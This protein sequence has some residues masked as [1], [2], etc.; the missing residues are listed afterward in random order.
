MEFSSTLL[1]GEPPFCNKFFVHSVRSVHF[2][3]H[4]EGECAVENHK[5][6]LSYLTG[7]LGQ[8]PMRTTAKQPLV[9][10]TYS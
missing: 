2:G 7:K 5:V 9:S 6:S 10:F 8:E 3:V 4:W 1:T